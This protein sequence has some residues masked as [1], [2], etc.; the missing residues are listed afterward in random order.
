MAKKRTAESP[1][2]SGPKGE[3]F[4]RMQH[5]FPPADP[6]IKETGEVLSEFQKQ[7]ARYRSPLSLRDRMKLRLE[8]E[9]LPPSSFSGSSSIILQPEQHIPL[10][11]KKILDYLHECGVLQYPSAT[12]IELCNDEPKIYGLRLWATDSKEKTDGR[13]GNRVGGRGFSLDFEAALSKAVGEFL[14]RYT[15]TLYRNKELL[16]FSVRE[17]RNAN[18]HFLDPFL[19]EQFSEEQKNKFPK[20][21]FDADSKFRWVIGQSLMSG[22]KSLIP[23]QRVY[24]NYSCASDEPVLLQPTSNGAGGMF[25]PDEAIISGLCELIQRDAFL[26]YWMNGIAPPRIA[27]NSIENPEAKKMIAMC[28]RYGLEVHILNVTSDIKVPAIVTILVDRSGYGPSVTL[29]G[30]CGIDPS[31]AIVRGLCEAIGVR[32]MLR[33]RFKDTDFDLPKA[34]IPFTTDVSLEQRMVYW[35]NPGMQKKIQFFLN[36]PPHTLEESF[37]GFP[38][39][40]NS[41]AELAYLKGLFQGKGER[42]E[43]FYYQARHEI[44]ETLGYSSVSVSVPALLPLYLTET[45]APLGNP[46]LQEACAA[47]GHAPRGAINPIPHPFP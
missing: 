43:I 44:L 5:Y 25:T 18:K 17:I 28:E 46:R 31:S 7:A 42:Y 45:R 32:Y 47:L 20:Y 13:T 6:Y 38:Q 37:A 1:R 12:F 2:E 27:S 10:R 9:M 21:R 33:D 26:V 30:G 19:S 14:E 34:Y 3:D 15:L 36:G 35:G 16:D 29:G 22:E 40:L 24:W 8:T 23:A 41:K 11:W 39:N 4:S